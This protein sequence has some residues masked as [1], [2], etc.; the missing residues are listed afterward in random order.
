M[1]QGFFTDLSGLYGTMKNVKK[2]ILYT[3]TPI[4]GGAERHMELLARSLRQKKYD[5]TIVCSSFKSLDDWCEKLKKTG[6]PIIRISALHKH[7]PR[8]FFQLKKIFKQQ[9][10]DI[11]HI[12]LWNPGACRY[13]FMAAARQKIKIIATEHDPFPLKGI[14]KTL[15]KIFLKKTAH[16]IAISHNTGEQML[17]LYPEIKNHMSVI[18]NGIDLGIFENELRHFSNQQK[19]DGSVLRKNLFKAQNDDFVIITIAALHPR[20]GLKYLIAAMRKIVDEKPKTKLMIAGDGPQKKYLRKIAKKLNLSNKIRFLGNQK[21]I[22][23]ILKSA[24][25]FVLP[26]IKE[27]FGLVLLEAMAAEIPI[28]ASAAGGIPEIIED[29]KNG[30][31]VEPGNSDTL[32]EKIIL[33]MKN[34]HLQKKL[35]ANGLNMVKQFDI[36]KMAKKTEKV[37]SSIP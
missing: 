37:Y 12:H 5:V 10:P 20:K 32:A 31:L 29:N 1:I 4:A 34:A 26:S 25:L 13:A 22:A 27:A 7:D 21:N 36:K 28:V 9:K 17:K 23:A 33:L 35:V 18:H 19:K 15:K 16:T 30:L 8:Q 11:L 6:I 14:K 24:D 2:I 3:D